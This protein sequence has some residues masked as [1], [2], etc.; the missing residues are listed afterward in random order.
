MPSF[1]EKPLFRYPIYALIALTIIT[2]LISFY[3]NWMIGAAGILLLAV[4]LFFIKRADSL[5]RKEIDGYISTLS[6]RLKKVGE[7]ALMEMPI[8]I[9]LFND[10]YYIEW[11]NPFLSSCFNESTLVGRSLYDTCESVVPLIKQEVDSETVTLNDRKFKVVIKRDERLLYF[12]DVT[13]QIQIEKQYENERTVLAYIFLDN[14]DDVTQGL[15]DQTRS[16]M[17][18]QVTSLL[19]NWAQEYGIF[20]KRTSSERFIGVLNEHILTEL[21]GSK[22][23]ILD[24]IREKTSVHS[25]SLTLS[26]G[27]GASVS[28]LKEL[29]DLAQSSLDLALG[30][31]GDQVAIKM[32]NGK[33]KFYGGKTNP[34]EKRTRVRARVISHALKEIVSESSNVIIMGH[35]FPDMDSIGAAIG[36]L[37]VAQANSKDGFIVIDPNQI[38]ASV[39]RLIEEIKKYEELWSRFITTE[40]AM[41]L[42]NDDTLLVIVDT[43]KP[44]LVMEERLVNKIEHIVVIDHHRRGEEFIKDPLLVYMEPYASSTAELVTEL[45]EYQPKRLKINMIEA[46]ALLAGIIV[47]TK[48]FSLRTGSR[49]FDAAS[50]LRAKGADT[51]L[52]QKFLKETVDS[53]IKRAKLIQHTSLYKDSIAIASLPE[54]AEEYFDQVLIAQTADS[55]LSMSEV[56][57]S[58][59]VARRDEQTVCIS[60]RSLG[61]VNV[62]IIMEALEGGGHLTNA[63]TQLSG[64]S[65]SEALERLRSAIDEYFE[66]GVQR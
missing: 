58:F 33:V 62:Q 47:D 18:S 21:E 39:Q 28:S 50:Y 8:G 29:G 36:I 40:E 27:V 22:F 49:T 46:T 23:S 17:N 30:R 25:V 15:D 31:G 5:I 61:E 7:E 1:Y 64:I 63:A 32:P 65:V 19:N 52:V 51:V 42:A 3:F 11:A 10:Q 12:F 45:L 24:E 35:K 44:S 2:V 6:Y 48:S 37:K 43:H 56:E 4:I 57:A 20:L 34:M 41:E 38:G 13:E 60:A 9:M 14:Y 53:Y 66:G 16:T 55:L 54:N 26:I 59:A